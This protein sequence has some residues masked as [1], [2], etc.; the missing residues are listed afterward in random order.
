[1]YRIVAKGAIAL[2]IIIFTYLLYRQGLVTVKFVLVC[3][4]KTV[5]QNCGAADL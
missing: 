4:Q 1:M 3:I 5:P 2:N